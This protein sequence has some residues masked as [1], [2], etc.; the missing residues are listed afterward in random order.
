MNIK[1]MH[2]SLI[3]LIGNDCIITDIDKMSA[4]LNEPRK[5]FHQKASAILIPKNIEQVQKIARFANENKIALIPQGGNTGLV[6]GQVPIFGNEIILSLKK[7]TN[8]R[9]IS[10]NHITLEAGVILQELHQI[11]EEKNV[12]FPLNIASQGSAQIGG[13]L[14]TNAGGSQVLAYGNARQLCTGIEAV[15]ADGSIYNGLSSLKKDNTGYDLKNLI[16][17]SEGTLAIITAATLRLFPKPFSY[18]TALVAIKSPEIAHELFMKIQKTAGNSLTAFEL[19]PHFGLEIQLKHNMLENNPSAGYS[20]YYA[21]VEISHLNQTDPNLL[22]SILENAFEKSL[23]GDATN[24]AQSEFERE[25]MWKFREQMSES[26]SFEGAS[27]KHDISVS[28]D[29]VPL[30]IEMGISAIAK[31]NPNIRPC[32]FGHM[33]D[34][35]IHFNFSQPTGADPKKFMQEAQEIH[36]AI[37]TI[38]KNL[39]GS[40]SAEHGIG[41][42]KRELLEKTKDKTALR[43]MKAIKSA[44]DPNNILNPGKILK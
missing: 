27:I 3:K 21:L 4:F 8:I 36:D 40:I 17:G 11:A 25:I 15:L 23:I 26:Q 39:N 5:R 41:Q 32:P 33:G 28:I 18:E 35:N 37:Y 9:S 13:I 31:I 2:K 30:L 38:V 7:L 14:A 24:I 19:I 1:Q 22:E 20:P 43:M 42:L 16:I 6:G 12:F 34:G 29:K 44:L 10:N